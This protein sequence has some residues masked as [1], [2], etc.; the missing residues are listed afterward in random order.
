MSDALVVLNAGSSSIKFSPFSIDDN[1][2][3]LDVN[4][5]IDGITESARFVARDRNGSVVGERRWPVHVLDHDGA[6]AHLL[7]FI[8]HDLAR[9]RV[10]AVGHRIVHGGVR[11]D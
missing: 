5:Q 4:G 2:L 3:T 6:T 1:S 10:V 9:Y 8:D 11:F 7:N